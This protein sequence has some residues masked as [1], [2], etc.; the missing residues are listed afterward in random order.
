MAP[1]TSFGAL[2]EILRPGATGRDLVELLE[3]K[4]ERTRALHWK[5]GRV[6]AP[7]WAIELLQTKIRQRHERERMIVEAAKPGP[8]LKAGAIN[9]ARYRAT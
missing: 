8:G 5:A 4:A 3:G 9:L 1:F 7:L 2:V 6:G